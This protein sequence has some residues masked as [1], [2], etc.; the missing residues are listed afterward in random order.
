MTSSPF[1][2]RAS[3]TANT[4]DRSTSLDSQLQSSSLRTGSESVIVKLPGNIDSSKALDN[5]GKAVAANPGASISLY[6]PANVSVEVAQAYGRAVSAMAT[7]SRRRSRSPMR[8]IDREYRDRDRYRR[9]NEHFREREREPHRADQSS[10]QF[11]RHPSRHGISDSYRPGSCPGPR[12]DILD[13]PRQRVEGARLR[14]T[15]P[16]MA[17]NQPQY[18]GIDREPRSK[19]QH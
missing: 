14:L 6:F 11:P 3:V 5:V 19:S 18:K 16:Q 2:T 9:D 10:L 13:F 12:R 7:L 17:K 15:P 8:E 1:L 4:I